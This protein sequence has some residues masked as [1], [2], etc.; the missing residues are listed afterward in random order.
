[1]ANGHIYSITHSPYILSVFNNLLFAKRVVEKNPSAQSEVSEIIPEDYWLNAAEF[2]AYS[3]G[4]QF[5]DEEANYCE[6]IFDSNTGLIAQNYLDTVSEMMGGEF[7]ELYSIHA[8]TFK[9]K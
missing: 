1:M 4:N 7:N 2:S 9:R 8:R 6:S 3:L 5:L